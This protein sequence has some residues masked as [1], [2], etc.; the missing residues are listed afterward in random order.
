MALLTLHVLRKRR[1]MKAYMA[2]VGRSKRVQ[3]C[4]QLSW[5][6]TAREP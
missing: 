5:R 6:G 1:K 3:N 4:G 2:E